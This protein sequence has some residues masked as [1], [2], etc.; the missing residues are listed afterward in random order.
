MFDMNTIVKK[1]ILITFLISINVLTQNREFQITSPY[2]FNEHGN[3]KLYSQPA[4]DWIILSEGNYL[5]GEFGN[6]NELYVLRNDTLLTLDFNSMTE[7]PIGKITGIHSGQSITTIGYS[8]SSAT[9]YLGTTS[10]GT[11]EL[12]SLNLNT[13]AAVFIGLVG[14]QG[15]IAFDIDCAGNIYSFDIIDDQLWEINPITGLGSSIG[16][17][18]FDASYSLQADFDLSISLLYIIAFNMSTSTTQLRTVDIVTGATTLIQDYGQIQI[19]VFADEG[20]CG[21]GRAINPQPPDSSMN[22]SVNLTETT[23]ENPVGV[24]GNELW[25]GTNSSNLVLVLSGGLFTSYSI[26]DTLEYEQTYYWRVDEIGPNGTSEGSIWRFTT[27]EN[28]TDISDNESTILK[29]SLQQ[30]YPNPFNPSTSIQ[31]AISSR[32]FVSLKVYDVLGNEITTLVNEELSA[33]E[34]EV[35]FSSHSYEGQNLPSGVYFYQIRV[36][37]PETSSEQAMIQTKKMIYLK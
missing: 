12:Y 7:T 33:G 11:S 4:V 9:M 24:I 20:D 23:W 35:E 25:W 10:F 16:P 21:P 3:N 13:A 17:L 26:S 36:G 1:I 37:G 28:P 2:V 22:I 29:F 6:N 15:L 5:C 27:E 14:Q 30:N 8:N 32:Q 19:T 18:G 34:Y 31:Y